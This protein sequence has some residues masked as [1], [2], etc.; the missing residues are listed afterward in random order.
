MHLYK[1]NLFIFLEFLLYQ[2]CSLEKFVVPQ[3]YR[4]TF[5]KIKSENTGPEETNTGMLRISHFM[6]C[7]FLITSKTFLPNPRTQ[8]Q[9]DMFSSRIFIRSHFKIKSI[10]HFEIILSKV[11]YK[12][13][14]TFCIWCLIFH[15]LK[16][17]P[18]ERQILCGFTYMCNLKKKKKCQDQSKKVVARAGGNTERLVKGYKDTNFQL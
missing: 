10:M 5:P 11:W 12:I 4:F 1:T 8:R 14:F 13:R 9:V 17:F 6:D 16:D 15:L 2:S 7:V 18:R 3:L